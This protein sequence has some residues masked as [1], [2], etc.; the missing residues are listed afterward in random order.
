MGKKVLIISQYFTPD[1]TA[2]AYRIRSIYDILRDK[3]EVTVVTTTPH[4]SEI[5]EVEFDP[6]ILRI[7]IK[8][9][10]NSLQ[11]VEFIIKARKIIKK[12]KKD[13]FDYIFVSSPPISVFYLT[14]FFDKRVKIITDIRDLWPDSIVDAGKIKE[15]SLVFK[16]L[17]NYEKRIYSRSN[18]L[19]CVSK[20]MKE[21]IHKRS[22]KVPLVIYN[23]FYQKDF[24]YFEKMSPR[25]WK[26]TQKLKICYF[27][28][29]GF[30]Q[31]LNPLLEL[32]YDKEMI[33]KIEI[34]IIG[35]GQFLED[36]KKNYPNIFFHSPLDREHLLE[37][38]FN[39]Y[40][41]LFLNLKKSK[42]FEKTIPSKLFDYLLLKKPIISGIKG[43]GKEILDS[44]GNVIHFQ[45]DSTESLKKALIKLID[46]YE[47]LLDN[48]QN[49]YPKLE[50]FCRENNNK[51]IVDIVDGKYETT[52]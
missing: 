39:N 37:F 49:N 11:Y 34:H 33:K 19:T 26:K 41:A 29:I 12:F 2:A 16:M 13:Y 48:I 38:V 51:K 4:K 44:F 20:N 28:N 27:G 42:T 3:Y 23:G 22:G 5:K 35:N 24:F 15:N 7:A 6:K 52:E 17:H 18:Y 25:L 50:F 40:D 8:S 47:K 10:K 21:E 31:F 45:Q 30:A 46:N 36:Y 9:K 1:I 32:S 43:E 14:N